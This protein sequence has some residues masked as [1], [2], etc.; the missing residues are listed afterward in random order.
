MAEW[1]F[2]RGWSET[3]LEE[4]LRGSRRLRRNFSAAPTEMTSDRGW[5][6][7]AS[8]AAIGREPAGEPLPDAAF[9]RAQ[10][11]IAAY[12]FS[13]PRIVVAH[14]DPDA[15]L[16]GRRMLL[17][18]KVLGL[19]YLCGTVVGAV[20]H[21][22]GDGVTRFG[23]R[24]DTLEGHIETGAEWFLLSKRHGTGEVRLRIQAAWRAG[25]FPNWWSRLG[26]RLLVRRYQRAWHRLAYLR[27][28]A[29]VGAEGLHPLPRRGRLIH[30]GPQIPAPTIRAM[31][32]DAAAAR[33]AAPSERER[34]A[35]N[36]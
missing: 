27:L 2:L 13:D 14:F 23:Y 10:D 3:E 33:R 34:H 19:H 5:H 26:F 18:I 20:H 24:Y 29:L 16:E 36:E 1:R 9:R 7:Y 21:G 25:D 15:P 32:R 12:A 17:E 30:E 35:T 31:S 28:R 4:R 8:H 22:T 11:A 6:A